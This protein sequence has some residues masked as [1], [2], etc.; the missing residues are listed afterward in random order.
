ML[1]IEN[2]ILRAS[3]N[4][5]G[6]ELSSLV[7]KD[8][9]AEWLWQGD[10]QW[11][12]GR[13]PLLFPVVGRSPANQVEIDGQI[14]PMNPHGFA[15]RSLF[16]LRTQQTD[17]V[18]LELVADDQSRLSF[19]FAFRLRLTYRL[20]GATLVTTAE[21][22]NEDSRP[23]P[24]QFGYHPAFQWPLPQAQGLP[25]Q[26]EFDVAP[27][28][29]LRLNGDGLIDETR[30]PAPVT[31]QGIPLDSDDYVNDAMV[32]ADLGASRFTLQA[33]KTRLVMETENLPDFALWQKPG[34]PYIC[35]EPWHGTAPFPAQGAG[36]AKRSN[37]I[38]LA[39]GDARSF[40]MRLSPSQS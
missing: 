21:V 26:V 32:F 24:F 27:T 10:A 18:Q 19:P 40:T 25:H 34:A 33:G 4:P 37:A 29:L 11:W 28:H 22:I 14:H 31:G 9:G 1:L 20:D 3:I 2:D 8:D 7:T 38:T 12:S 30:H 6:A 13:A 5:M 23:M 15:R 39:A 36:L 17:E 16:T 35:L